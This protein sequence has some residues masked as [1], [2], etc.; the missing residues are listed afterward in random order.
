MSL[1]TDP[2]YRNKFEKQ[3]DTMQQYK[4]SFLQS[5]NLH[6]KVTSVL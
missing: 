3:S 1:A 5:S 6:T 4:L 2:I